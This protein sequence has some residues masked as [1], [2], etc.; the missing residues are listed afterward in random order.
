MAAYLKVHGAVHGCWKMCSYMIKNVLTYEDQKQYLDQIELIWEGV[1]KSFDDEEE[2]LRIKESVPWYCLLRDFEDNTMMF[3]SITSFPRWELEIGKD[4]ESKMPLAH[5]EPPA[6]EKVEELKASL[7]K[8]LKKFIPKGMVLR[9]PSDEE[10]NKPGNQKYYDSGVIRVDSESATREDGPFLYQSFMTGP[11]DLREVWL[12]TKAYKRS[13]LWWHSIF[14]PILERI[15]WISTGKSD[16]D[17]IITVQKRHRPHRT[18]DLKGCGIQFPREYIKACM[19][20]LFEFYPDERISEQIEIAEKLF[21]EIEIVEGEKQFPVKRGVGLG[22]YTNLMSLVTAAITQDYYIVSSFADDMLID[23]DSF[24]EAV[25]QLTHY[26]FILNEKKT[27]KYWKNTAWFIGIG[28]SPYGAS[29]F[30]V[31]NAELSGIF[32]ARYHWERKAIISTLPLEYQARI[33]F[34]HEKIYG[35]EFHKT[36]TLNNPWDGGAVKWIPPIIGWSRVRSAALATVRTLERST[37]TL[38]V[39]AEIKRIPFDLAKKVHHK[40]KDLYRKNIRIYTPD[41]HLSDPIIETRELPIRQHVEEAKYPA[42]AEEI[43]LTENAS[44]GKFRWGLSDGEIA[45]SLRKW[46]LH[47]DPPFAQASGGYVVLTQNPLPH[48]FVD[49]ELLRFDRITSADLLSASY[50]LKAPELEPIQ[51]ENVDTTKGINNP[52]LN[53]NSLDSYRSDNSERDP[54]NFIAKDQDIEEDEEIFS[55]EETI[56]DDELLDDEDPLLEEDLQ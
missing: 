30:N 29:Y 56:S 2:G 20:V 33:A 1:D 52:V 47:H 55:E 40:R 46:S 10:V 38:Q 32:L 48:T 8:L 34:H 17:I 35:F 43:Q 49:E 44:T 7:R 31:E 27:G 54:G 18:L 24:E 28:I 26:E 53:Y 41:Y 13:S 39:L 25:S 5:L 14:G 6:T 45:R 51:E 15:P 23:D 36:D 22:Y 21:S 11:H 19:D 16:E 9:I 50:A 3:P 4:K 12:P 42:W 37:W